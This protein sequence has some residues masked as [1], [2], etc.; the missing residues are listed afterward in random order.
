MKSDGEK[1]EMKRLSLLKITT[2]ST[3]SDGEE[4]KTESWE[5]KIEY[6]KK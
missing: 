4:V 2:T 6:K 1:N 5:V 3:N